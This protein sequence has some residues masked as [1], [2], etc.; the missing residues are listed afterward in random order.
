MNSVDD[1][2]RSSRLGLDSLIAGAEASRDAW[3]LPRAAG[4]WSPAQIVEHVAVML[5]EAAHDVARA[6][7]KFPPVP[8]FVRPIFRGAWF[9]RVLKLQAFPKARTFKALDPAAGPDTSAAGRVRLENAFGDFERETRSAAARGPIFVS[10]LFGKVSLL[11]Y[12]RFQDLHTRHHA[13]QLSTPV[14]A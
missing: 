10:K 6:P 7:C 4:R 2:L 11:D 9:K 13:Q 1:A 8:F 3:A 14:H 5:E 12:I